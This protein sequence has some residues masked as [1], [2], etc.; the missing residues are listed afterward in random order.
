MIYYPFDL[1]TTDN[2]KY[3]DRGLSV[4]TVLYHNFKDQIAKYHQLYLNRHHQ[5]KLIRQENHQVSPT[6]RTVRECPCIFDSMFNS[7]NL[8]Q[9]NLQAMQFQ[10]R[11]QNRIQDHYRHLMV[12]HGHDSFDSS[13]DSS[14][15]LKAP[16]PGL[17]PESESRHRFGASSLSTWIENMSI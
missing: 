1:R 3:H 11:H 14:A 12:A 8:I 15:M 4:T 7:L 16:P 2:I 5:L 13:Y 6:I 17:E 10:Q 9:R